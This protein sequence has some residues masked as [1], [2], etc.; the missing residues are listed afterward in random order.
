M[1]IAR[2]FAVL[3][4]LATVGLALGDL[5]SD[6][7]P[8][9]AI[10]LLVLMAVFGFLLSYLFRSDRE[11]RPAPEAEPEPAPEPRRP[12]KNEPV[13][14]GWDADEAKAARERRRR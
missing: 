13:W 11:G 1:R 10:L 8:L 2:Y 9:G 12:K 6:P 3:V 7:S 14:S 4:A 5:A